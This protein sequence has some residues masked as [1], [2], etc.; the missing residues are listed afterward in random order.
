M[1][2]PIQEY[3]IGFTTQL[4][5]ILSGSQNLEETLNTLQ[6]KRSN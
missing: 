1:L 5:S 3:Q 6:A 4:F 2:K